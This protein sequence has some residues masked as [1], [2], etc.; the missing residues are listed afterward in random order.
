[1]AIKERTPDE[2]KAIAAIL[3]GSERAPYDSY[4]DR[5]DGVL[6]IDSRTNGVRGDIVVIS[7]LHIGSGLNPS[8]NF[9]GNENFFADGAMK[10]FLNAVAQKRLE[11]ANR[12]VQTAPMTL[13]INGDFIDFLRITDYP[14]SER[15]FNE[16]L[17]AI[18][19]VGITNYADAH[20]LNAS[21]A[22]EQ[23]EGYG[24]KT[25]DFKSVWKLHVSTDGHAKII[26]ALA[27]WLADGHK[28]VIT[29]GNHDLEWF[30]QPVR[31]YLR[32]RLAEKLRRMEISRSKMHCKLLYCRAFVLSTMLSSW[33]KRFTSSMV[34]ATINSQC[35]NLKTSACIM[36]RS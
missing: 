15:D 27:D 6:M 4:D 24:L 1:M 33:M 13:I 7:D 11:N 12:A 10:R 29:K 18:Q 31:N 19:L 32:Y 5:F 25:N 9:T 23:K 20:A 8:D 21:I 28:L 22:V 16:W 36:I 35:W 3:A 14:D 34:I 26:E 30:W 2:I 17:E